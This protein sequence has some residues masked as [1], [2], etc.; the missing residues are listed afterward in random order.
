[1]RQELLHRESVTPL[2]N[3][4]FEKVDQLVFN[5][6]ASSHFFLND[7]ERKRFQDQQLNKF[8][9]RLFPNADEQELIQITKLFLVLFCLD[10]RADQLSGRSRIRFWKELIRHYDH[11]ETGIHAF[12]TDAIGKL[13]WEIHW[14]WFR[15][16]AREM[17][18]GIL[19]THYIRKFFK[20][21]LWEAK[22]LAKK[23]PPTIIK[24]VHQLKHCS[25]AGIAIELLGYL[26]DNRFPA[27]LFHHPKLEPLYQTITEIIC[28]SNDLSSYKKEAQAGD[29]HNL[30]LLKELHYKIP[31]EQAVEIIKS[32]LDF[33]KEVYRN[34]QQLFQEISPET[35]IQD[36]PMAFAIIRML[37]GMDTWVREDT[38][39]Y[40]T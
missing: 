34:Q 33:L 35:T 18:M 26:Q 15:D 14:G 1:M 13:F 37:Q 8:A 4:Y 9:S 5:W 12:N 40:G 16:R 19:L 29:F 39:R 10:D 36:N 31:R 3:P 2:L 27:V 25:G 17:R 30:V 22:N 32:R 20:A 24:Y 38:K 28:F 11:A 7:T 23:K 6:A 21:G